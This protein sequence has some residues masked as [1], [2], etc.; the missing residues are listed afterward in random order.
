VAAQSKTSTALFSTAISSVSSSSI[1][2]SNITSR[3]LP[4]NRTISEN[5]WYL[6]NG[7][8][9]GSWDR[10][11]FDVMEMIVESI[12]SSQH[13]Q[14]RQQSKRTA[15]ILERFLYRIVQEQRAEN[16]YADC[17]DMTALYTNLID[18]WANSMEVGSAERAEE[19]LDHF[20]SIAEEGD[21]YDPLLCGPGVQSFN[22]VIGAYARSGS[23][24]APQQAIRVLTK[25]YEWN[26]EG[27][28]TA[29]PNQESFSRTCWTAVLVPN[30]CC[31]GFSC[32]HSVSTFVV[33][34]RCF[35]G[36]GKNGHG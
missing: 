27:R 9:I 19:I 1:A 5:I 23:S 17:V 8:S 14:H 4:N 26:K 34:F 10:S 35:T 32:T 11:A 6:L 22:A 29:A 31:L 16:P 25:L 21:S 30:G 2:A 33:L 28:T 18:K 3:N 20:Q 24:D 13:Q 36:L 7:T 12:S 15:L